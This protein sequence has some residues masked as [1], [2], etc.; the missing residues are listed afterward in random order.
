LKS[1]PTPI[2]VNRKPL[3]AAGELQWLGY[4]DVAGRRLERLIF[5]QFLHR[6]SK[7][8]GNSADVAQRRIPARRLDAAK[9]RTVE[10]SSRAEFL[11]PFAA[12]FALL[13]IGGSLADG[14]EGSWRETGSRASSLYVSPESVR[15]LRG[16]GLSFR[17]IARKTGLGYGTVRRAY[18]GI[19]STARAYRSSATL[20]SPEDGAQQSGM[21]KQSCST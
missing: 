9:I 16:R 20:K 2:A 17:E 14:N 18:A 4:A 1:Q 15:D 11:G 6:H 19:P 8:N 5:K 13:I 7:R 3:L 10:F 21:V 12:T